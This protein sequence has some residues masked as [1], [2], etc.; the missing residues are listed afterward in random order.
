MSLKLSCD[1]DCMSKDSRSYSSPCRLHYSL[2][3]IIL[4]KSHG[5]PEQG[6]CIDCGMDKFKRF[7]HFESLNVLGKC[8]DTQPDTL[9]NILHL[10]IKNG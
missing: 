3:P 1:D 5:Q 4:Y 10:S 8:H 9:C 6:H 2:Q 7:L